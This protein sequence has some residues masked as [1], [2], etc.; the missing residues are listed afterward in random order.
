ML[1]SMH[2]NERVI[3][4]RIWRASSALSGMSGTGREG[5]SR[6]ILVVEEEVFVGALA[7]SSASGG[8]AKFF[9]V[10]RSL[11]RLHLPAG[12]AGARIGCC[13][14]A[15]SHPSR[16]PELLKHSPTL[17]AS[18]TIIPHSLLWCY[19]AALPTSPA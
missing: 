5:S 4:T 18:T 2:E 3:P 7:S 13:C 8:K 6:F 11:A 10:A 15:V 9:Q 1:Q 19:R 12:K 16:L 17:A 14:F